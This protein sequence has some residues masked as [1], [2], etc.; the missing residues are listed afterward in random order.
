MES[1]SPLIQES[2]PVEPAG[3]ET[4]CQVI[5]PEAELSANFAGLTRRLT[6]QYS[7]DKGVLV[8]RDR[9]G[10]ELSAISTWRDGIVHDGLRL[11]LPSEDSLFE[12]VAEDGRVYTEDFCESFSGNFFERKLLLENDSRCFVVQPLLFEGRVR[13]LLGYSSRRPST[14]AMF[15]EGAL[16][17]IAERFGELIDSTLDPR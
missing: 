9:D 10:S 7:I 17:E 3:P 14:F 12:K 4:T 6:C 8:V 1:I 15:A 5:H 11:N 13:G 16:D 2:S